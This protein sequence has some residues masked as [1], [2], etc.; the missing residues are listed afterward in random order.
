MTNFPHKYNFQKSVE[1]FWGNT[2]STFNLSHGVILYRHFDTVMRPGVGFNFFRGIFITRSHYSLKA[3]STFVSIDH[4]EEI[5]F[6]LL[7]IHMVL[8]LYYQTPECG[9]S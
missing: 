3:N 4:C 9:W 6:P 1:F 2:P 7:M 8:S 5:T